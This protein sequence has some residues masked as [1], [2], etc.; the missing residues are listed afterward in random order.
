LKAF[1]ENCF[2]PRRLLQY[3]ILTL[4]GK[5]ISVNIKVV[6]VPM[7]YN[8]LL[9]HSCFYEMIF[10]ASSIFHILRF[11]HQGKIIIVDQLNYI[12]PYLH[13]FAANNVPFVGQSILESVGV[14]LLKD[15]SLK[16]VF[17]LPAPDTA[18]IST[19]NMIS[20]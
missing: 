20:T 7:D 18:H 3:F 12:T 1:D 4:K 19:L 8:L 13:N 5:T 2:H 10:I 11:P 16:G 6:D 17:P 14:D 15:S 9:G